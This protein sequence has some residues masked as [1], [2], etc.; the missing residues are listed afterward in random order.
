MWDRFTTIF[1]VSS[2]S[3]VVEVVVDQEE[4]EAE[5]DNECVSVGRQTHRGRILSRVSRALEARIPDVY[6]C[7]THTGFEMIRVASLVKIRSSLLRA[8]TAYVH[9]M[10][11][12]T[13]AP[14]NSTPNPRAQV[15]SPQALA[16]SRKHLAVSPSPPALQCLHDNHLPAAMLC[17]TR[18]HFLQPSG[19]CSG[20]SSSTWSPSGTRFP[21]PR[22]ER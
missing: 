11:V 13:R 1:R 22:S 5:E 17:A 19:K 18:R 12:R 2:F 7:C 3:I 20:S 6:A 8:H 4:E 10:S 16:V 21:H 14:K 15:C 9:T